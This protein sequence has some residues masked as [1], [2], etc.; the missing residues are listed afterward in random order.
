[1]NIL[2]KRSNGESTKLPITETLKIRQLKAHL[3]KIWAVPSK[4]QRIFYEDNELDDFESIGFS[5]RRR[6]K[7][8][9][10]PV[11]LRLV[12][13]HNL[14]IHVN[15][16]LRSRQFEMDV[17]D[18]CTLGQI[19][20][21]IAEHMD[22]DLK[23]TRI[24][25]GCVVLKPRVT[26]GKAFVDD[27]YSHYNS[28]TVSVMSRSHIGPC[29]IYMAPL[30]SNGDGNAWF[31]IYESGWD[32]TNK[33]WCTTKVIDN[34]GLF[35]ATIPTNIPSGDY[36]VRTELLA[37]HQAKQIGGAQFYPNCVIVTVTNGQGSSQPK[38]YAIPGIYA[39]TDPGILYDRASDP[40]K[41]IIPG[42]VVFAD[43]S[44][45]DG[46]VANDT[47]TSSSIISNTALAI[48]SAHS[49]APTI[50]NVSTNISGNTSPANG[51]STNGS[52]NGSSSSNGVKKCGYKKGKSK[53]C[54]ANIQA[55]KT[56]NAN[57]YGHIEII[58]ANSVA[59]SREQ[60]IRPYPSASRTAPVT[61]VTS[62]DLTCRTS[63]MNQSATKMCPIA[64]GSAITLQWHHNNNST[65]DDIISR[66]H[67]GPVMV[68]MAPLE[69]NGSGNVWFKI[70]ENGWD[71][72]NKEWATDKLIDN[73]G[74]L[75][76]TIPND[77]EAGEYLLR[78]EIIA[79]HNARVLGG[80]QFFPNCVQ[81]TVTGGGNSSPAGVALPG[82]Y[83]A[84]DPGI[85]YS[86][87]ATNNSKYV[88]PGPAI[89]VPGGNNASSKYVKP[90][91]NP[92]NFQPSANSQPSNAPTPTASPVT[93]IAIN[94]TPTNSP[95]SNSP[96]TPTVNK[97]SNNRGGKRHR[98]R[99]C[100]IHSGGE[101]HKENQ[102]IR[103]YITE[104]TRNFPVTSV[105]S[106]D[107]TCR[108][109]NMNQSATEMCSAVAGSV[110]TLHWH[111]RNDSPEDKIIAKS[112]TGPCIVYMAPMSSNGAGDVWF[113]VYESG[114]N[115]ITKQWCTDKLIDKRGLL[116]IIIPS[117]I[118]A[119]DYLLR[120]E[121]IA[122]HGASRLNG[123]QFFPNCV[124]LTITGGG[125]SEPTGVA[126][127]GYYKATDPGILYR[128]S[129]TDNSKYII[130]GPPIYN[131][132]SESKVEPSESESPVDTGTT[133]LG[134]AQFFPNCVQ[135]TVAGSGTNQSV[136]VALPG[137]YK[138]DYSEAKQTFL[139][140]KCPG[141]RLHSS[142]NGSR[143]GNASIGN[144]SASSQPSASSAPTVAIPTGTAPN[145]PQVIAAVLSK[146]CRHNSSK[147]GNS[148]SVQAK[149][150]RKARKIGTFGMSSPFLIGRVFGM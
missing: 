1:M 18:F 39:P 138:A 125:S 50:V 124:Q 118:K 146:K 65:S 133:V 76:V 136:G 46:T 44:I 114:W 120:G 96:N 47:R 20:R 26:I 107:L 25:S 7:N 31:K 94:T 33:K 95:P 84:T 74:V 142:F 116:D 69:S 59:Y 4:Q 61:D 40:T 70:Y 126:L 53:K 10:K 72:T 145:V 56:L 48:E 27:G 66:S 49:T 119:G 51:K 128:R 67:T 75:Q 108:T 121:I 150:M 12:V 71:T 77:I 131:P 28:V 111:N 29:M 63:N 90:S 148:S 140:T 85:L 14:I 19:R 64:A 32:T 103:P 101:T 15:T 34:N 22:A 9:K 102:C 117:N 109:S 127:P 73:K 123:T 98:S 147:N 17:C 8:S 137:Y 91:S 11:V 80:A 113:K 92:N 68:Y 134:G 89:Y 100:G 38:G 135:L 79:L 122:L 57:S 54:Q 16:N 30:E 78:T 141:L 149:C 105:T 97:C 106:A 52:S 93:A 82:A 129:Q 36:I 110:V 143:K 3:E 112:H 42:P 86:R 6:P 24:S 99:K 37:L 41:Y 55:T 62:T 43:G 104:A 132:S 83:K 144:G 45:S 13:V 60:C 87:S 88:I 2:V 35:N 58:T 115:N 23:N 21:F 81:L 139:A 5:D 130:P